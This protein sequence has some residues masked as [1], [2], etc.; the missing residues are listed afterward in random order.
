MKVRSLRARFV[1]AGC[2]LV[3]STVAVGAW[4]A[5][6]F[7]RLG[8]VVG[9]TLR[10]SEQTIDL[11]TT[12]AD[13]LERE[14][15]ALLLVLTG[16]GARA[17]DEWARQRRHFDEAYARL[18]EVLTSADERAAAAHLGE[19]AAAYRAAGDAL[20]AAGRAEAGPLYHGRVNPALRRA[21]ADCQRIREL[22]YRLMQ[23]AG[24][25]AGR[26]ARRATGL[27]ALLSLL[28]L[29]GSTLVAVRLARAILR[30]VRELTRSVE[31]IRREDFS[32][33][34]SA[35]SVAE[36][37]VLAE[38][39]NRMAETLA[40][41]RASS[42]GELLLA[43]A[44]LEAALAA[45]P[46]AVLVLDPDGRLVNSNP[47][48]EEVLRALGGDGAGPVRELPLPPAL[49]RAVDEALQGAAPADG[50]R[51]LGRALTVPLGGRPVKLLVRAA[52]IPN[53][54]PRR[55]GAVLVL[56]D[57]TEF[58][59]LDEL[60]SEL[61]AVASHELKT[62]LTAL[63]MNLLLLAERA[64][65]LAPRQRK[66]L[67][68][69]VG[70]AEELRAT[71]EELMDLT[72]IEAGQLRLA[73]ERVDPAAVIA[74]AARGLLPRFEDAEVALHVVNEA[75]GAAVRGDAAR[76]RVVFAN[77]LGNALKYTPRGGAVVVRLAWRPHGGDGQPLLEMTVTD[78]GPGIPAEFR[79]RVF[80]KFF[81]VEDHRAEGAEGVRG[82]GIGLYLCRQI[83]EAHGGTIHAEPGE[84]RGTRLV[85]GLQAE[86]S[87]E[88]A[89][90][91]TNP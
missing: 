82:A 3:S 47:L 75:P 50:R 37:R 36:L 14:D 64:D 89:A 88:P 79:E 27:V 24:V 28:A 87:E 22:N 9:G 7:A 21:V 13:A 2:L 85:I 83:V 11:T 73:R 49:R 52:P 18:G 29:L 20:L 77:L 34:V 54:L 26:E 25:E 61:V 19:D 59:R 67:E 84:G 45:L 68:A 10:E 72:R 32:Q 80:E 35:D 74:T 57:V 71:I 60:R 81:R 86:P 41:Y 78:T 63:Q 53:F 23:Q 15:D 38:A 1:L 48:G 43:K 65:G 44:T 91:P 33:R 5:F 76:L 4:S 58:A 12:L 46:D 55:R 90:T 6:T 70:G 42:L 69:A 51:D 62:P 66:V 56:D 16:E 40:E 8:A 31:G 39:F 17:R 30:P